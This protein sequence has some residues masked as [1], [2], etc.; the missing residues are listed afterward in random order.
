MF[1][2]LNNFGCALIMIYS[3]TGAIILLISSVFALFSAVLSLVGFFKHK[4]SH[5]L[6]IFIIWFLFS[7][8]SACLSYSY[9]GFSR[10]FY[11]L[12][13]LITIPISFSIALMIDTI[14]REGVDV[15]KIVLLTFFSTAM[16]VFAFDEKALRTNVSV[17]N[18]LAYS[19]NG[20]FLISGGIVFGL[21]S[22]LW[23]YYMVKIYFKSP[24][25]LKKPAL[26]NLIGGV[27]TGPAAGVAFISGAVWV[28]PGTD[29]FFVSIG[30]LFTSYSFFKEPKLG[31][32]LPFKAYTVIVF[33]QVSGIP[34]YS[35]EWNKLKNLN[36]LLFSGALRG[37]FDLMGETLGKGEV[38]GIRLKEASI[39]I[40]NEPVYNIGFILIS[41]KNNIALRR[42]LKSFGI[43]FCA[44][45]S[46]EIRDE[47]F[48]VSK[49]DEAD[50]LVIKKFPFIPS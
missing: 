41:S 35:Y 45:Y 15:Y 19:L 12:G 11:L 23:F 9:W 38:E 43:E 22:V 46:E 13:I 18:E 20:L 37:I 8:S 28:F 49:F 42:G 32:I 29:Y 1:R 44:H 3:H 30:S 50:K 6:F 2:V 40:Y 34:L 25:S 48:F 26:T 33:D 36:A 39:Q 5:F 17:Q 24:E 21:N 16:L 10:F 31:Y 4:Y 47:R 27:L 14:S 7:L